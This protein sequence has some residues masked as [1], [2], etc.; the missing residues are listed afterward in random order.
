MGEQLSLFDF[1]RQPFK[2]DKPIRLISLFSGYDSQAMAMKRLGV[3]FEHYR[4]VEFDKYA[5][6]SLNAVHGTNFE[7]TDICEVKGGD[8]GIVNKQDYTY[9]LTY[10]FP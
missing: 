7:P 2:I 6:A 5:I 8:L 4:A 10:S 1:T 9:V 3:N